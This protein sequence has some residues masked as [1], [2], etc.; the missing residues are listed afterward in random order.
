MRYGS[1]VLAKMGMAKTTL[2]KRR[3]K[4]GENN[5]AAA[6]DMYVMLWGLGPGSSS[7]TDFA[8][9]AQQTKK[10]QGRFLI[11]TTFVDSMGDGALGRTCCDPSP[12]VGRIPFLSNLVNVQY[13]R[14]CPVFGVAQ[15]TA[16]TG[17]FFLRYLTDFWKDP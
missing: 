4:K 8:K 16:S 12:S 6:G 15:S 5:D 10:E 9:T 14:T 17:L 7:E 1:P 11:E 3:K 2:E 13:L